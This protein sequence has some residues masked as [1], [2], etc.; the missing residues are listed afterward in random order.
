MWLRMLLACACL[1]ACSPAQKREIAETYDYV[2]TPQGQRF[3]V[4]ASGPLRRG[5]NTQLGLRI[6][7]VAQAR[8]EGELIAHADALVAALGPELQ[9]T[10]E[11]KLIVRAR[12][13]PPTLELQAPGQANYDLVYA[14]G[15]HGFARDPAAPTPELPDL[16][17]VDA[18]DDPKFPYAAASLQQAAAAAATWLAALDAADLATTRQR[19]TDA[20][21]TQV[22]DDTK[23]RQL[24]AQR[25]QAGLPG[26]RKE[27]YRMQQRSKRAGSEEVLIV[28]ACSVPGRPRVLERL[29]MERVNGEW[30]A[31]AYAFQPLPA[32]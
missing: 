9:L 20:F 24:L 30:N 15:P 1:T 22:A 25:Q 14:L 10:G 3:R 7:Y 31:S 11:R 18:A 27:L 32:P 6:R 28:Y 16:A 17:A 29:V 8:D 2:L 13:G 4:I 5:A 12:I 26:A 19:M 23:Y 21:R